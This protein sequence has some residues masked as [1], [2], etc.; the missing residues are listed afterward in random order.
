MDSTSEPTPQ[1]NLRT[2][3]SDRLEHHKKLLEETADVLCALG[4]TG[5]ETLISILGTLDQFE[6]TIRG[7]IR[8]TK[9]HAEFRENVLRLQGLMK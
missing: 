2:Y 8:T 6:P 1:R 4:D 5:E 7:F 3:F 9:G